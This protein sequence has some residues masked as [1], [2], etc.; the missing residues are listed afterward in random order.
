MAIPTRGSIISFAPEVTGS[1][2]IKPG[3]SSIG[4]PGKFVISYNDQNAYNLMAR[5]AMW[6]G[7]ADG[8]TFGT[9]STF[10]FRNSS[11][12]SIQTFHA[13][14]SRYVSNFTDADSGYLSLIMYEVTE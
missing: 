10:S 9:S 13:S 2:V 1:Q 4:V 8:F 7:T 14:G 6:D 12:G 11:G 5:I 3:V